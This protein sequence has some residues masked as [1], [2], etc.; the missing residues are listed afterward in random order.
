MSL[1]DP[2]ITKLTNLIK[3]SFRVRENQDPVYIDI[4]GHLARLASKQHQVIFGRRGSGKSCLLVHYH[5]SK[6]EPRALSIYTNADEVKTLPYPDLSLPRF[7]GLL[8]SG[9]HAAPAAAVYSRS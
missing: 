3:D 8:A 7:P 6:K 5:R 9:H 1:D 2:R 4:G